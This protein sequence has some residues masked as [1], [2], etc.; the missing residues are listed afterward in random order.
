MVVSPAGER[1]REGGRERE[2]P[3][4]LVAV[5]GALLGPPHV[6]HAGRGDDAG[7]EPDGVVASVFA[8]VS[9]PLVRPGRQCAAT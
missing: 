6:P 9:G 1:L 7:E 8:D 4:R 2:G 5:S 3:P